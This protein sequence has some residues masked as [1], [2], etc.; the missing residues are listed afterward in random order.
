MRDAETSQGDG[1]GL[2]P[3]LGLSLVAVSEAA[4]GLIGIQGGRGVGG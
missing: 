1:S 3:K 2:I 4:A